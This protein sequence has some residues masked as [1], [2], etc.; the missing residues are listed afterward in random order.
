MGIAS[1]IAQNLSVALLLH[2]FSFD[3]EQ[4]ALRSKPP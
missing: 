2:R 1:P 3:P 4:E